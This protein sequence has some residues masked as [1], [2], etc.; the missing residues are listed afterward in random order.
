MSAAQP[1]PQTAPVD[2]KPVD[3]VQAGPEAPEVGPEVALHAPDVAAAAGGQAVGGAPVGGTE[4]PA[5]APAPVATGARGR[6]KRSSWDKDRYMC[7]H[8]RRKYLCRDC[9][10]SQICEHGKVRTTCK[11]CQEDGQ[12]GG[13]L[14]DHGRRRTFCKECGGNALCVHKVGAPRA[15]AC[16]SSA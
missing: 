4:V 12:G 11:E 13:T 3:V 6:A 7:E 1:S 16:V 10:G 14:C 8:K 2:A 5:P 9:G 15:D